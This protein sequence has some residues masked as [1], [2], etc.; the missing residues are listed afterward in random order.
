MSDTERS[1]SARAIY[2]LA[3]SRRRPRSHNSPA[4]SIASSEDASTFNPDSDDALMSTKHHIEEDDSHFL[5]KIRTTAQGRR[6]YNPV[7]QPQVPSSAVRREFGDFDLSNSTNGE[8]DDSIEI[9]RGGI[10]H[11]PSKPNRSLD[12]EILLEIGNSQYDLKG[13]PPSRSRQTPKS[14]LRKE[15]QLRRASSTRATGINGYVKSTKENDGPQVDEYARSTRFANR[16]VSGENDIHQRPLTG[17]PQRVNGTPRGIANSTAQSFLLPEMPNL[18]EL[19]GGS[20]KGTPVLPRHGL[21][22]R[23]VA[24]IHGG[25]PDNFIPVG[26]IPIPEEEKV[27]LQSLQILKDRLA[28]VEQ[29]KAEADR[30]IEEYEFQVSDLQAQ[31]D[32][33]TSLRRSDSALGSSD[34]EG[35]AHQKNKWK[36]EKARTCCINSNHDLI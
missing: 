15:A 26:G 23:R 9:G 20:I 2:T 30:R 18:T 24:S 16:T 8:E 35:P 33:H 11:T 21:A 3:A 6:Y 7:P 12:S 22:G 36:I 28:Q 32:A 34:G 19:F 29:E 14:N 1:T 4:P 25:R 31:L 27:I 13:T 17:T 10:G 5:P